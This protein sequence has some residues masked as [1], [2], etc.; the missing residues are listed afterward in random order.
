MKTRKCKQ[1]NEKYS[2]YVLNCIHYFI[3]NMHTGQLWPSCVEFGCSAC[4]SSLRVP[5]LPPKGI[6]AKLIL[7]SKIMKN[8]YI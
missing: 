1:H 4:V 3:Y 6:H 2:A 5:R 8:W 7:K